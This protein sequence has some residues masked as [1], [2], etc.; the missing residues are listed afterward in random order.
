MKDSLQTQAQ[1]PV[2]ALHRMVLSI[3]KFGTGT[4]QFNHLVDSC[5]LSNSL[6]EVLQNV[7]LVLCHLED[8]PKCHR[9]R[10][11]HA[12]GGSSRQRSLEILKVYLLRYKKNNRGILPPVA[13]SYGLVNSR[14]ELNDSRSGV[15]I[16]RTSIFMN[17]RRTLSSLREESDEV[18]LSLFI[19]QCESHTNRRQHAQQAGAQ[20]ALNP[21]ISG[22]ETA[23]VSNIHKRRLCAS[24]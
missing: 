5:L 9:Y 20:T 24:L 12:L 4:V 14:H 13:T 18:L 7:H 3:P 6:A 22:F 8:I 15:V 2:S 1:Q 21:T 16:A 10:K 17:V 19:D 11:P 23:T